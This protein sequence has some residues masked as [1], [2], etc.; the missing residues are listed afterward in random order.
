VTLAADVAAP[1]TH[2]GMRVVPRTRR[3]LLAEVLRH[4][5]VVAP[6]LPP[7]AFAA[8]APRRCLR[9]ADLYDP[10]ELEVG[11]A[12][13]DAAARR[14]VGLRTAGRRMHLRRADVVLCA[15]ERQRERARDDLRALGRAGEGPLLLTVP[16]GL[17]DPPAEPAPGGHAL[18]DRFPAIGPDDPVVVWWGSVWRWLDGPTAVRAIGLLARRRPDVRLV[19]TAGRPG[20][21]A[22]AGLDAAGELRELARREGLLDE[23]VFLLDDWVP[24]AERAAF[25][26]DAD[27]GIALHADTAEA[28]LAARS[29]YMDLVWASLPAILTAGDEVADRLA[30]AGAAR[31]VPPGDAVAV[32][33]AL[34]VV[35]GDAAGRAAMRRACAEVA[36][37]LR[38]P[39]AVAPLLDAIRALPPARGRLLPTA[40]ESAAYYGRVA[41]GRWRAA[42]GR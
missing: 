12:G 17:P 10:V 32:A 14:A 16:M 2:E 24:F 28:P 31:L 20:A 41:G 26:R 37:T 21:A 5:V 22:T 30:A 7:F 42:A 27:V 33:D 8:L 13:D 15:N 23:H 38:W 34:D 18:R 6:V 19:V 11:L 39:R 1:G 40:A 35:L 9:V 29:R 36:E 4:D 25:L 3:R